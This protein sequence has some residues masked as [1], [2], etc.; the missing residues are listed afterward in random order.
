MCNT[1]FYKNTSQKTA[2]SCLYL[3]QEHSDEMFYKLYVLMGDITPVIMYYCNS[4]LSYIFDK[5]QVI[6]RTQKTDFDL[7]PT[8]VICI[9]CKADVIEDY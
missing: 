2:T 7:Q 4:P 6:Y 5:S 1:K 3:E 9:R 8:S